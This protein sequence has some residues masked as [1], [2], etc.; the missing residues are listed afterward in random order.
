[1]HDGIEKT[2]LLKAPRSRVWNAIVDHTEF[3][4]WFGVRLPPG[5][6]A[7]GETVAGNITHPGYEH[8]RMTVVVESVEPERLLSYRWHPYAIDPNVDYSSEPSTL[9]SFILEDA[10][11]GTQLTVIESGFDGIP[12]ERRSEAW[13]MNDQGWTSQMTNIE[14]HVTASA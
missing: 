3:G 13:R 2:L 11:G 8:L 5:R 14:R 6:F 10:Q 9:V 4:T 1:M 7:T 12:A